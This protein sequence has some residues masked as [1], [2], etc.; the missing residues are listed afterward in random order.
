MRKQYGYPDIVVEAHD[1][2]VEYKNRSITHSS[3]TNSAMSYATSGS[4]E[5]DEE[6]RNDDGELV[7]LTNGGKLRP[8]IRCF[9][10]KKKGHFANQCPSDVQEADTN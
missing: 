7:G 10:C 1:M 8:H 3:H 2:I 4:R 6:S 5:D 9:K